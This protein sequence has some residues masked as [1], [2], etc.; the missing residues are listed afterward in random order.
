MDPRT[1]IRALERIGKGTLVVYNIMMFVGR[2][3]AKTYVHTSELDAFRFLAM[4]R[5]L[6]KK[7]PKL[8]SVKAKH[9]TKFNQQSVSTLLKDIGIDKKESSCARYVTVLSCKFHEKLLRRVYDH[10]MTDFILSPTV[11]K[12]ATGIVLT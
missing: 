8:C 11:F 2:D 12:K 6:L 4:R 7:C 5:E 10:N 3:K 1:D 9:L